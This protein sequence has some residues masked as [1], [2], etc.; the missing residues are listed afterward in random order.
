MGI[1]KMLMT[2]DNLQNHETDIAVDFVNMKM[3]FYHPPLVTDQERIF[4]RQKVNK[5]PVTPHV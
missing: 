1:T 3:E 5:L 2:Y 4:W